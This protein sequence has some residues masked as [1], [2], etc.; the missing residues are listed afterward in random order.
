MTTISPALPYPGASDQATPEETDPQG[1]FSLTEYA[2]RLARV[3]ELMHERG[4]ASLVVVD[5]ANLFYLTGYNAWSFYMPQAIIVPA[6]GPAHLFARAMDAQ[7]AHHT[8]CLGPEQIHGYPEHYVH[9]P[10]IHPWDWITERAL[11]IGVLE[12]GAEVVIGVETDAHFFSPRGFLALHGRIRQ[13]SLIDSH[14]LVNWVRV[15]K[16][17]QEQTKLLLAGRIATA[18]M[19]IGLEGVLAGAPQYEVV[20]EIQRA[21]AFGTPGVGGDYPAI[22]PMLPTGASAGT[23]HLT[24]SQQSLRSG[25]ATTIELAGVHDRYHAPLARTVS[26]GEPTP[27]LRDCSEAV[28]EGLTAALDIFTPGTTGREVHAAFIACIER[29]GFFK[30]SRIGYSI[31]IG[32]PPDWGERTVSLRAEEETPL[33]AGMAFHIILGMWQD[34]WGY[35]TSESVLLTPTG[36]A[37][38]TDVPQGLLV[39]P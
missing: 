26:L 23:P 37:L 33:A 3:Q 7:G 19:T 21:Q 5:P 22:V 6:A 11:E 12:D 28:A 36:H 9:R 32:Y 34:N 25:E 27:R 2:D 38:L 10:D 17:P 13:A 31:G 8:C 20:S 35:E 1:V 24:W 15:I 30:E 18:A 39:K 14:E 29:R 4:M 16:S